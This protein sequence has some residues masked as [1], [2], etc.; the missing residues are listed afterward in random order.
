MYK[1][2]CYYRNF[3]R[4]FQAIEEYY[5]TDGMLYLRNTDDYAWYLPLKSISE[6]QINP[7]KADRAESE[8][9]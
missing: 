1:V 8:E 2:T 6:I 5:I 7:Y 4:T 3:T 9:V